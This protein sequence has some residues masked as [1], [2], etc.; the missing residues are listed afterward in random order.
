MFSSD[1]ISANDLKEN[2]ELPFEEISSACIVEL[3]VLIL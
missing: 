2:N 1:R 3:E